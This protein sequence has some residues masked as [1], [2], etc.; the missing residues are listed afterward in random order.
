MAGEH[1]PLRSLSLI[2]KVN[3]IAFT[4]ANSF[5]NL[6]YYLLMAF[7]DLEKGKQKNFLKKN[8]FGVHANTEP[9]FYGQPP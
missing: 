2:A 1:L 9:K 5:S 3:I 8:Y 7:S 6:A 4:T